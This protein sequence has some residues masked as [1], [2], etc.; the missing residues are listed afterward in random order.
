M[1]DAVTIR[2]NAQLEAW[3]FRT[4]QTALQSKS[5]FDELAYRNQR[6]NTLITGGLNFINSI[7]AGVA[8]GM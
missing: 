4:Q 3:G 1:S 5:R 6:R 8:K 7:G 2:T